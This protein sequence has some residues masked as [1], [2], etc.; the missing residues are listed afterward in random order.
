[1]SGMRRTEKV[2]P[3]PGHVGRAF[4]LLFFF[5]KLHVSRS[6][7]IVDKSYVPKSLINTAVRALMAAGGN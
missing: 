1:M 6:K 2:A 5:A 7:T 3:K 4:H